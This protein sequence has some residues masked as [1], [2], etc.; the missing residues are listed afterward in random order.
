MTTVIFYEKSGCTGNARQKALLEAAGHAVDARDLRRVMWTRM[1]LLSFF[2]DLPVAD[3][4]NRS[5]PAVKNGD[6]VPEQLDRSTALSLL[7]ND[8]LLIRRPLMEVDEQ[9]MVGF[10]PVRVHAWIGLGDTP[11][12]GNLDAC[13]HPD[14]ARRCPDPLAL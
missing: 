8:P 13:A 10:D 9:R 14:P 2:H 6:I 1:R 12:T 4:F 11:P 3:W 7:Q 5:A